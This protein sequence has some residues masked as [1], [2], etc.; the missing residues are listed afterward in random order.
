MDPAHPLG[1]AL[2]QV[3]VHRHHVH[4]PALER[5]EVDGQRGD[6]RLALAGLHLG[7]PS[8]VQRHAA[9]QLD[10]E[11]T[12]AE[13]PPGRLA[14]HGVGLDQEVVEGL[15][16]VQAFA[17]YHRLVRERVVAQRLHL[18]LE[19][20]DERHQLLE[21]P[22]LLALAG[23]QDL[24]E[25][26]HGGA[27]P[28]GPGTGPSDGPAGARGGLR[29][30]DLVFDPTLACCE[31]GAPTPV[32]RQRR[33]RARRRL[34]ARVASSPPAPDSRGRGRQGLPLSRTM[35]SD[36]KSPYVGRFACD[37]PRLS[38][39]DPHAAHGDG[40]ATRGRG[41]NGSLRPRRRSRPSGGSPRRGPCWRS[42][43]GPRSTPSC[44]PPSARGC[45]RRRHG[46]RC[47]R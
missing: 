1:V 32:A 33:H 22:D 29:A 9:H 7:D 43:G 41:L 13:H 10:V 28:T 40:T 19:G 38:T 6:E 16:L 23:A 8:E 34:L 4:A 12:L 31:G 45:G 20:A 27:D 35:L 36:H 3:L 44:S 47:H 21:P 18:R 39:T 15:A 14:H 11:M 2:G 25:H 24:R 37:W 26:A 46:P 17:E 30:A 5:V 42:A